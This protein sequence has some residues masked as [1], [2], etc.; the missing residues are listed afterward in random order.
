MS[1]AWLDQDSLHPSLR[2]PLLGSI[3]FLNEVMGRFPDAISFAPGAPHPDFLTEIDIQRYTERFLTHLRDEG[4][5]PAQAQRLL[6]EYGPGRG[7][8]NGIVGDALARDHGIDVDPDAIVITVGAQEGMLLVLRALFRSDRD[9]LAVVD[10]CFVGMTGAARLLD[11]ERLA[12]GETPAGIDLDALATAC[13]QARRAGRRIRA[14]YVAPD[15]SNPGGSRMTL[16]ARRELLALAAREDFFVLEDDAYAFTAPSDEHLPPL[17]ALDEG[18]RVIHIGTFAKVAFPGARVGYVL[19]DQ[20]V[21]DGGKVLADELATIKT[22]VTVNTSPLCQAVI[23]GML[24]EHGRSLLELSRRK[25][26]LYRRNLHHLVTALDA[27]LGDARSDRL[28]WNRP[29]GGFFV[30]MRLP[31]PVTV[32]LLERSA[33]KY[34]VLWTPMAQFYLGGGGERQLRLSCSY[35]D[36]DQIDTG[37]RRLA[38]FVKEEVRA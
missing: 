24:L 3:G 33:S 21:G 34:G 8:I 11:I 37:V 22:M 2:D 31:V 25:S 23:G 30:R 10:P 6:Y 38:A 36:P 27:H 18:G 29:H 28:A 9:V 5:T 20:R 19:A 14:C 17:K 12:I 1:A 4:R 26:E 7:I 15:F 13:R 16:A 32:D 35:L